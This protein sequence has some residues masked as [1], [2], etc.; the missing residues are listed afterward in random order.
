MLYWSAHNEV[1]THDLVR[2]ALKD[3]K[4]VFLPSCDTRQEQIYPCPVKEVP[5]DLTQ[6]AFGIC[7]P[8]ETENRLQDLS[9]LDLCIVPGI[10]FDRRGNRIGRGFGYYDRF[11]R[12]LSDKTVKIGVAYAFQI[13]DNI[14]PTD[15]DTRVDMVVTEDDLLVADRR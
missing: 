5:G 10:A 6:G 1:E 7:E 14:Y 12:K 4:K 8:C 3:G 2:Q 9:E 13:V 15:G 11:L